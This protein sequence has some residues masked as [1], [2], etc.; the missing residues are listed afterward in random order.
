MPGILSFKFS[1][2]E[3]ICNN[4]LFIL[5]LGVTDQAF[6]SLTA[7]NVQK[8]K[9]SVVFNFLTVFI[10]LIVIVSRNYFRK[11]TLLTTS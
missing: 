1:I 7:D 3:T 10:V 5:I 9:Q 2:F 11:S 8:I 4:L 6:V